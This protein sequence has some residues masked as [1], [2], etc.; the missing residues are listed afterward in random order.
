MSSCCASRAYEF[1]QFHSGWDAN[2][3]CC[4]IELHL[5][6]L[7]SSH[8]SHRLVLYTVELERLGEQLQ[9]LD[10]DS[11]GQA[12]LD[13]S[14]EEL[15]LTIR[16]L[17]GNGTLEGF[18]ADSTAGRLSFENID[19]DRAFIRRALDQLQPILDT[20]PARGTVHD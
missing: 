4:E 5:E 2:A 1:P 9:A 13:H 18:L 8:A 17:A 15:G 12:T 20:F 16:L 11:T 3:L 19:I 7:G 10:R 14:A 6:R